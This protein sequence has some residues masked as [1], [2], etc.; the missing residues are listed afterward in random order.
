MWVR[1]ALKTLG[2][3]HERGAYH[4]LQDTKFLPSSRHYPEFTFVRHPAYWLRSFWAHRVRCGWSWR[5]RER[6]PWGELLL[7]T[8][9]YATDDANKFIENITD[10][11]PGLV[12]WFFFL[13][14]PPGTKIGL[15][16][17]LPW[18]LLQIVPELDLNT[19]LRLQPC[20]VG[21]LN[22]EELPPI[23][24]ENFKR[25]WHSERFIYKTHGYKI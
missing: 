20:N 16:E 13:Y 24:A 18:T 8:Q 17:Q 1:R 22:G 23:T 6:S 12:T 10:F 7:R 9:S 15:S 21:Y 11:E 14:T 25:V 2:P 19:L 4:G 3:G 5:Q